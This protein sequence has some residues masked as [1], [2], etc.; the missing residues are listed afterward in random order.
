MAERDSKSVSRQFVLTTTAAALIQGR[1][2]TEPADIVQAL[3]DALAGIK[4]FAQERRGGEQDQEEDR[5]ER[6]QERREERRQERKEGRQKQKEMAAE[7][8][9]EEEED[10]EFSGGR[11]LMI[12]P[13][14]SVIIQVRKP[15]DDRGIAKAFHDADSAYKKFVQE[16]REEAKQKR[17]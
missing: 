11:Q 13:L 12:A 16:R 5:E 14:A 1:G 10:Q 3:H 6:R 8:P 7:E 15:T 2:R 9:S 17:A 4:L